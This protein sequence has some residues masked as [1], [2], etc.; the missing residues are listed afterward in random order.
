VPQ[1]GFTDPEDYIMNELRL[2]MGVC[3]LGIALASACGGDD[4]G[5]TGNDTQSQTNSES[6][7]ATVGDSSS[8][9][10][11][12]TATATE[13]ATATA[14]ET[15][16]AESG[17]TTDGTATATATATATESSGS[18]SGSSESSGEGDSSSSGGMVCSGDTESCA[19][20][21]KCCDGLECCGGVPI[22]PGQ[23]YCSAGPCP[24]SD[25]NKKENFAAVDPRDVLAK[26]AALPIT[27]WNYTFEDP[28]VRHIGPMAQDFKAA[29]GVGGSDKAI[30]QVDA[31]G[32]VLA[33]VQA[34]HGELETLQKENDELR[35][36]LAKLEATLAKRGGR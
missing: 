15:A 24:I 3:L 23:E 35:E 2:D 11:S 33:S 21:E 6:A 26:V 9:S 5:D 8:E 32:V 25:R 19:M 31:D 4:N 12:A 17:D 34:L 7:P 30:F 1:A 27:S 36:R 16:T 28:N 10:G 13:T 18:D 29:F 20:G 22:P 14:T